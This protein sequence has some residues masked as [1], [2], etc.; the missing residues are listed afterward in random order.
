MRNAIALSAGLLFGLGLVFG[1]MTRPDVVLGFLD[2]AGAWNPQ[3]LLVIAGAVATTAVGYRLAQRRGQPLLEKTFHLPPPHRIDARL[4]AGAAVFGVGWGLAG[5]CPGPALAS[6]AGLS[7]STLLFVATM[8]FGWW[9][10]A[11]LPAAR[12]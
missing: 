7:P 5:Y 11:R 10:G 9:L 12:T 8:A 2:V 1:G 4:L 3:M 6:L